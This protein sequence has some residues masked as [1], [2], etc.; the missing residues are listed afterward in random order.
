MH[1]AA[2]LWVLMS[3]SDLACKTWRHAPGL[4]ACAV[5]CL[6]LGGAAPVWAADA[7]STLKPDTMAARTAAC[8][9]C[10]G[11]QGRAGADGYYPRLA[12]KPQ[13]YLYHQLLN[14][15]D[16]R[17]RYR[18]MQRL[19]ENLPD[20][21]LYEIAGYFASQHVPY[22]AP[23]RPSVPSQVLEH[24]RTLA[25]NGDK[26]RKLPACVACHG[27]TF[28]GTAPA[29]PGLLGLPRDYLV[30]QLGSWNNTLRKAAT[31]DCM[32]DVAKKLSPEDIRAVSAW[33]ASQP[34]VEPYAPQPQG[35]V[36][37][38]SEC[39]SQ[40]QQG[41]RNDASTVAVSATTDTDEMVTKG[42]YLASVGDCMACHTAQGG[43]PYAGGKTIPTPFG[44]LYGPN[45]TPDEQTGIGRWSADDF[46]HALHNGKAPDG[47]L[48]YPAFPY[49]EYTRISR[50]DAD[51]L[52][53]FLKTVKP[54]R[55][56]SR[57]PE[58]KFPYNQRR[59][60]A[61]WRALYF[62][63]GVQ[64]PD[65]GQSVQWNRGRYL[66]N[67]IGHCAACHA[68]R[69]SL[70]ATSPADGLSGGM[71]PVLNWYAPPLTGDAVAGMGKWSA[72]DIAA[73]LKTGISAHSTAVGPM[74]EVVLGSSQFL[75]DDDAL[76]MGVYLKTLP[77]SASHT[78]NADPAPSAA[79]LERGK[80]LY[81]QHCAQCHQ[82]SGEGSGSAWPPLAGNPTVNA[83][84]AINA[85]RVVLD[86]GFAPP[87]AANPRPHSM[88]PF[89]ATLGDNEVAMLVTYIR[90][91][92]GNDAGSVSALDVN[93]IREAGPR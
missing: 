7:A 56:A 34:I 66:V 60:M 47:S 71:I 24:G 28:G 48:L 54:V 73:L 52:Y 93:R 4:A 78:K 59:L 26:A 72:Q 92:W 51:A 2:Q 89:G 84:S 30:S 85:I 33:L 12:G 27:S 70:G 5:A 3:V 76:A 31:P 37:L 57:P 43:K 80:K 25:M 44:A 11:E 21:Y 83:P 20:A 16:N 68:P 36:E 39:G 41:T 53:A 17:R 77:A 50:A 64:K 75:T 32:A 58:L 29:I 63:P 23:E 22:P 74:G 87:T 10:H 91:S 35:S 8:M 88:P 61:G 81:T 6:A 45:I 40:T 86:G 15:R 1:P 14:F 9:F 62:H 42:R 55:Q 90:N 65:A 19:L 49:T 67:G 69:N 82:D 18:P 13:A 46:W 79:S 38:P